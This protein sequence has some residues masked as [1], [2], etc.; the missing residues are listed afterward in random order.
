M[1]M[2]VE[3]M[4]VTQ[5]ERGL[6][7]ATRRLGAR[8]RVQPIQVRG[9]ARSAAVPISLREQGVRGRGSRRVF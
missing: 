6:E 9:A 3:S 1:C 4:Q 8:E 2:G 7:C 5:A